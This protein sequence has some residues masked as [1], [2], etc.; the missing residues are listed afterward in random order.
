[1]LFIPTHASKMP[2][3]LAPRRNRSGGRIAA[4]CNPL[5]PPQEIP[6][7]PTPPFDQ[8][9]A[10][11]QA[12]TSQASASSCSEYSSSNSPSESPLPRLSTRTPAIPASA[13]AG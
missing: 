1:M 7:M 8:P 3:K 10:A 13:K 11:I 5:N 4:T 12:I 2:K 9:C 6:I